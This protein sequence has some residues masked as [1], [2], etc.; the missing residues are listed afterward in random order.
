MS[1]IL[2]SKHSQ[3]EAEE[4]LADDWD[5]G[6]AGVSGVCGDD[7]DTGGDN[8]GADVFGESDGEAETAVDTI[9]RGQW[10]DA[11]LSLPKKCRACL[12]EVTSRRELEREWGIRAP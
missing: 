11:T 1:V 10:R 4:I 2:I 5:C 3:R 6:R 7:E 12:A 9:Q 8:R